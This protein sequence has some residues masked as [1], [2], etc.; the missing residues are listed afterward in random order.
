[1]NNKLLIE[2]IKSNYGFTNKEAKEYLKNISCER[3][4]YLLQGF[5][6]EAKKSF[7]ED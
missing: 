6:T 7:E 1:M 5:L 2:I 4:F 3:K